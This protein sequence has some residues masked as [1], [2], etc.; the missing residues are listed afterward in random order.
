M[1]NGETF[2][3]SVCFCHKK[4]KRDIERTLIFLKK[5]AL[6]NTAY[7]FHNKGQNVLLA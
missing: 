7:L 2:D 3:A 5:I 4:F 1:C 6:G